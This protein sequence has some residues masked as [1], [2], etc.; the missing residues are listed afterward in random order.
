MKVGDL[1]KCVSANGVIGLVVELR[2]GATPL[3]FDVLIGNK[4]YPFLPH[5][6]ELIS[7][8]R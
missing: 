4:S 8:S 2:R 7:E 5:Q 6:L 1:V 3:V